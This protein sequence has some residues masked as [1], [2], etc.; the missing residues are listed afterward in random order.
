MTLVLLVEFR[1]AG[2]VAGGSRHLWRDVVFGQTA[3]ARNR[4]SDGARRAKTR[5]AEVDP[6]AGAK[7]ALLG[8]VIGL[9]AALALTRWMETLAV[10][11]APTDPLTFTVI[12]VVLTLVALFACYI[13]AR[14]ATKVD[15]MVAL[16]SE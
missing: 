16:R 8:V 6:R 12:A 9:V 15:P 10:R 1:G 5:C 3:H 14:R 2:F 11:R 7:L 13:P 4:H